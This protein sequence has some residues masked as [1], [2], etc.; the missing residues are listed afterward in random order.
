MRNS[1][2]LLVSKPLLIIVVLWI[3]IGLCSAA[4]SE[5]KPG[6]R[7]MFDVE[8]PVIKHTPFTKP[9]LPSSPIMIEATITDNQGIKNASLNYRV[10]GMQNYRV[11]TMRQSAT[12]PKS[13]VSSIPGNEVGTETIEYYIQA[14]DTGGNTVLRGGVLF[15]LSI[16]MTQPKVEPASITANTSS[17]PTETEGLFD[18]PSG[19]TTWAWIAGGV[20][21]GTLVAIS[22]KDDEEPAA[23]PGG[24]IAISAT[25][26]R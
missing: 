16:A 9:Q 7:L 19:N 6:G 1:I 20:L 21:I 13:Y 18:L 4:E 26:P 25:N 11:L 22:S 10:K 17:T 2:K 12:T 23:K 14:T 8:P 24:T 3:S 15:P 5:S